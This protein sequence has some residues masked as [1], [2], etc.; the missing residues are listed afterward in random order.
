MP[1]FSSFQFA[2]L[3][4]PYTSGKKNEYIFSTRYLSRR[5][6]T[7]LVEQSEDKRIWL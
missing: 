7:F 1:L 3:I 2:Q 6:A 4:L 5:Y